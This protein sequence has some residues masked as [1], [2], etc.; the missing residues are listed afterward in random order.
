MTKNLEELRDLLLQQPGVRDAMVFFRGAN[1]ERRAAALV[2]PDYDSLERSLAGT[3]EERKRVRRF[4]KI[5]D[6]ALRTKAVGD[7]APGCNFLGWNSSYTKQPIPAEEML[8]W[9][10]RTVESIR[11]L[12]PNEVLEIGCGSGLLL[13][14]LARECQSFT[15]LDVSAVSLQSVRN[16]ME[17]LGGPWGA[18]TLLDRPADDLGGIPDDSFDTVI[19]NSVTQYFLNLNYLNRVIKGAVRVVKPGGAVFVGDVRNL[20]L[21]EPFALSVE[22]YQTDPSLS[23]GDFKARVRRRLDVDSDLLI[24]PD[25][26]SAFQ[27]Q[28]PEVSR[29]EIKLKKGRFENEMKRFRYDAVLYRAEETTPVLA[30][31]WLDWSVC[32]LNQDAIRQL[33]AGKPDVLGVSGVPNSR[34]EECVEAGKRLSGGLGT[35]TVRELTDELRRMHRRGIAPE[36]FEDLGRDTGYR[37]DISWASARPDGAYDVLFVRPAR[38]DTD[39]GAVSWPRPHPDSEDLSLYVNRPGRFSVRQ[40]LLS[41]LIETCKNS[42]SCSELPFAIEVVDSLPSGSEFNAPKE[43]EL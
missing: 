42:L 19:I 14:R 34:V 10:E 15:G 9:V 11:S 3:D 22:L 17:S 36:W 35:Q 21:A 26:F 37:V 18:V 13:L 16:Q 41:Q 1:G 27:R 12:H 31:D 38:P 7:T 2:V 28:C 5:Y 24:S 8:D 29:V 25:F 39:G 23:L 20:L 30:P 4:G 33:L 32:N 6:L 40:S 43:G